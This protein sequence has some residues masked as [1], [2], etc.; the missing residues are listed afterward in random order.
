MW[1]NNIDV[2][3]HQVDFYQTQLICKLVV[4]TLVAIPYWQL[5]PVKNDKLNLKAT[6]IQFFLQLHV[7]VKQ[8]KCLNYCKLNK[9][10]QFNKKVQLKT[11][12][13]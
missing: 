8:H 10:K 7:Y 5:T 12:K 13:Q 9:S 1:Q 11:N 4:L 3:M 6:H 2:I